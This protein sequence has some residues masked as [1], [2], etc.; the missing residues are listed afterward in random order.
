MSWFSE[1]LKHAAAL[2]KGKNSLSDYIG[3]DPAAALTHMGHSV[4]VNAVNDALVSL[5]ATAVADEA[6]INDWVG[7]HI[8]ATL[9]EVSPAFAKQVS[10]AVA[11]ALM[12]TEKVLLS[13]VPKLSTDVVNAVS[14]L[15]KL[16]S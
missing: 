9:G 12:G 15:L 16:S 6:H 13:E 10:N 1:W 11:Y 14:K 5:A 2:P 4:L 7:T 3:H 8:V